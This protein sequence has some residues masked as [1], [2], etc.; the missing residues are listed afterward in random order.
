MSGPPPVIR[1]ALAIYLAVVLTVAAAASAV[2]V[3]LA[4]ATARQDLVADAEETARLVQGAVVTSLEQHSGPTT[5][6]TFEDLL[7]PHVRAG[8]LVR[9]KVWE[10]VEDGGTLRLVY[11]DL[12]EL[13]GQEKPLRPEREEI[14]GTDRTLVIPVPDDPAH[15]TE[16]RQDT[17]LVEIFTAFRADGRDFL[18]ES[19]F[20]TTTTEKAEQLHRR[21]LPLVL[22]GMAVLAVATLPVAALLARHLVR[23]D[24]ERAALI[25]RA[26]AERDRER[27]RL[28]QY[29]HDGV[30]QDLAGASLALT[31]LARSD[32]PDPAR[33][34][35]IA[36]LL[37]GDV[38]TLRGLLE[39]LVP[40]DLT[41]EALPDALEGLLRDT[42]I[43]ATELHVGRASAADDTA[44]VVYR[45]TRELLIN[46]AEHSRAGSVAVTVEADRE[47]VHITV[48]D[49]GAGFDPDADPEAGH[50]GLRIIDH[51]SRLAGGA[52]RVTT[53]PGAGCTVNVSLPARNLV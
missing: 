5:R 11:S 22:G 16:F 6:D 40:P 53:A 36:D 43:P 2:V 38:R 27:A 29:L 4:D 42:G 39:D 45:I 46:A 24:R 34:E 13:I 49:D 30:V 15:R 48:S 50:V 21:V 23:A 12:E 9:V 25:D 35:S 47:S 3:A 28:G 37:R 41:W 33:I 52:T 44:E 32:H 26:T 51:I 1:R 8:T 7:L 20:E 18:L 10:R 19:Y 17:D 14:F 31:T